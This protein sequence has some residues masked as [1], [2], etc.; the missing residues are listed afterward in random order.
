VAETDSPAAVVGETLNAIAWG[1]SRRSAVSSL[2]PPTFNVSAEIAGV[3]TRDRDPAEAAA[4]AVPDQQR[5]L[6]DDG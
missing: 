6:P 1:S 3:V 4:H 5:R 2:R